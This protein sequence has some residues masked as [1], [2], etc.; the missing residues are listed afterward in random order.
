MKQ[1][2]IGLA[3]G[4]LIAV[5]AALSLPSCG[6]DQK[7]VSISILPS[8]AIFPSPTNSLPVDF[9]ATGTYIHPPE[10]KDITG[11]VTW[12]VDV[13]N[14]VSLAYKPGQGEQVQPAA[15][16]VCGI[17]SIRATAPEGTG[18]SSNI[19]ASA[20]STLTIENSS[21]TTC[22]GGGG[23]TAGTL[24]VTPEGTGVGTVT[25]SIGGISCPGTLCGAEFSP[26]DNQVTLTESPGTNSTFSNWQNCSPVINTPSQCAVTIPSGGFVNVIANFVLE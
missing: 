14:F 15:K 13:Q 23:A 3:I 18:G 6:H 1:R 22:P 7:L 19:V 25:S 21:V 26:P 2:Y 4:A 9:T 24:V 10:T 12:N 11:Q 17:A 8:Q 16:V 5:G 20:P